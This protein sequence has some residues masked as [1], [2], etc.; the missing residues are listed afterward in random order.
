MVD[1]YRA[2]GVRI[3]ALTS[4]DEGPAREMKEDEGLEFP[5]VYGVDVDEAK[6]KLGLY[7]Q[8]GKKIHLQPAQFLL[9]PDGTIALACYS[10][11]AVGRLGAGK[12]LAKIEFERKRE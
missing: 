4:E 11:G 1:D 7:I 5:V 12:A 9:R 10:S 3:I 2:T 8:K 6:E